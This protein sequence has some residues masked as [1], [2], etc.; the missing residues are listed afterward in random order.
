M[1][2]PLQTPKAVADAAQRLEIVLESISDGLLA[3]DA[4]WRI[5]L[6]NSRAAGI[7][8]RSRE[9]LLHADFREVIDIAVVEAARQVMERRQPLSFEHFS[10]ASGRWL[11]YRLSPSPDGGA[12]VFFVDITERKLA[13]ERALLVAQHDALTGLSNRKLLREEAE[14]ILAAA[15]RQGHRIAVLFLDL[16][17]FKP[18][19]DNHGHEVGDKLLKAVARRI[20]RTLR[21]EDVVGRIGGDEFVAVLVG[22][23]DAEDAGHVAA[24]LV[25]TI[26]RPYRVNGLTLDVGV[27]I[28][29]SLFPTHGETI[30][31]LFKRADAAMYAAKRGGRARFA[32]FAYGA[33][34]GSATADAALADRLHAAL[35]ARQF[36]LEYQPVFASATSDAVEAEAL[37]R[38]RQP[39]GRSVPPADFLPT[40]EVSGLIKA[41]GEWQL[42]E[43]CEQH[44]RWMAEGL[45]EIAI[46]VSVSG[47]QFRQPGFARQV[48]AAVAESGMEPGHLLINV[49]EDTLSGNVDDSTRVLNELHAYGIRVAL[50]NFGAGD[51]NVRTLTRLPVDK[52]RVDRSFLHHNGGG[53]QAP[54]GQAAF[55]A[56]VALGRSLHRELVAEGVEDE[57]DLDHLRSRGVDYCQ[58]YL[59]AGPMPPAEFAEWWLRRQ[60]NGHSHGAPVHDESVAMPP[61]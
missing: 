34:A 10:N 27:S 6:V 53:I 61:G 22:V 35:A 29:I 38:W 23:R 9:D 11:D 60:P 5:D 39:D 59:L 32:F 40:A 17:R 46:G 52:L 4:G 16:D 58:G 20:G 49:A 43:A 54:N 12:V 1:N 41:I 8:G 14:R 7:V 15:R 31:V 42:R 28:G 3:V 50:K 47:A 33:E 13:A 19:N 48:A 26:G 36:S 45:G 44:M 55:D 18:I 24:N 37:I 21:A 2:A 51:T 56:I 57:A 30:D 25:D